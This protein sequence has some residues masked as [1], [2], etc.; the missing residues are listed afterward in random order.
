MARRWV[1]KR[2]STAQLAVMPSTLIISKD[3][4]INE[5]AFN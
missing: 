5:N 1:E 2:L 3:Q 4:R